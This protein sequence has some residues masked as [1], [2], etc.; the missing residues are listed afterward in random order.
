M[1][2]S[3]GQWFIELSVIIKMFD[4]PVMFK[5]P[6]SSI[7]QVFVVY[8]VFKNELIIKCIARASCLLVHHSKL[9]YFCSKC[10]AHVNKYILYKSLSLFCYA[11][12]DIEQFMMVNYSNDLLCYSIFSC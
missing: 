1:L 7:I 8:H 11:C 2:G 3:F 10:F 5:I 4:W 6:G 9:L 12:Y